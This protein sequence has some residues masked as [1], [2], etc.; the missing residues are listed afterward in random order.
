MNRSPFFLLLGPV[1]LVS[2]AADPAPFYRGADLSYVN[3]VED[4]GGVFREK[5]VSV[6][7]FELFSR[8]GANLVRVRLWVDAA[9]TNYSNV[10]DVIKTLSRAR[11]KGMEGLLAL[12]YSDNWADPKA[13]AIPAAWKA[14]SEDELAARVYDYTRATLAALADAGA[15]PALVQIGNEINPGLLKR[16]PLVNEWDRD[17][18][19][20]NAGLK[21]V[22]DESE[23]RGQPVRTVL[24]VAQPQNADWWFSQARDHG[25]DAFDVIGLSYYPQWSPYSIEECGQ[26]VEALTRKFGRP[27]LIVETGAPWTLDR[28]PETAG[29]V[30]NQGVPGYPIRPQGQRDFLVDLTSALARHGG[31][32]L[33]YWEPAW[34]STKA[35]TRWG[36]GSHWENA[37]FF[38]FRQDNEVLPAIDFF[39]IPLPPR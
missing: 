26:A 19:L 11:D 3:E 17:V 22:R 29:N 21:A 33:V 1:L 12:H 9:W 25:L 18:R 27:V 36:Q 4:F 38:D 31:A 24:H 35:K 10:P 30:L 8:H 2:L 16:G 39:S 7:P 37:T 23:A 34:I 28:Y 5:G 20:L 14:L 15:L 32:G 6:D 13:Q